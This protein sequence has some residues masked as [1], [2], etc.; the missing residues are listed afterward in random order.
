MRTVICGAIIGPAGSC[1]LRGKDVS[2]AQPNGSP[3]ERIPQR[4]LGPFGPAFHLPRLFTLSAVWSSVPLL[5][6]LVTPTRSNPALPAHG[7]A[8][9]QVIAP[10]TRRV[11]WGD[12]GRFSFALGG[13]EWVM[14]RRIGGVDTHS[15]EEP[16]SATGLLSATGEL[17]SGGAEASGR[18]AAVT[19]G[20]SHGGSPRI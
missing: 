15:P 14:W 19:S 12:A 6:H 20:S 18:V 3:M 17:R 10:R 5:G 7:R 4:L 8:G 13:G 9:G 11:S 16:S 1:R 2:H